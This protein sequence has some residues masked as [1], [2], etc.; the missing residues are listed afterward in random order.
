MKL[1]HENCNIRGRE[2]ISRLFVRPISN[3]VTNSTS[4]HCTYH[5]YAAT[6]FFLPAFFHRF[7]THLKSL[8]FNFEVWCTI[9]PS[10]H[11]QIYFTRQIQKFNKYKE[12]FCILQA[13]ILRQISCNEKCRG[14]PV[15]ICG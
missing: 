15:L 1:K 14:F 12:F 3:E 2:G 5:F 4:R 13:L 11:F 10:I 6:P 9:P 8:G 7:L